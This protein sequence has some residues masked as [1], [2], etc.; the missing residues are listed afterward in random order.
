MDIQLMT[1]LLRADGSI[2]VN[3]QLAK[4]IGLEETVLFSELISKFNYFSS[5]GE[6]KDGYFYNTIENIE[7]DTTLTR[8]KQDRAIKKLKELNLIDTKVLGNP[9]TRHFKIL[10]NDSLEKILAEMER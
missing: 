5:R 2:I 6:T 4:E 7:R 3:K 9:A 8:Y 1:A 10:D